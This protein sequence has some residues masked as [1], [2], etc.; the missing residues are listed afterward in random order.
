M[1]RT[2][3]CESLSL[4]SDLRNPLIS[5][6]SHDRFFTWAALEQYLGAVACSLPSLRP[7][8]AVALK[9]SRNT[10][11][12]PRH[13]NFQSHPHTRSQYH[14]SGHRIPI[15]HESCI[16]RTALKNNFISTSTS[17]PDDYMSSSLEK[18]RF[19][20]STNVSYVVNAERSLSGS[21]PLENIA[22]TSLPNKGASTTADLGGIMRTTKVSTHSESLTA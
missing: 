2:L 22:S 21:F 9:N 19:G 20:F 8:V 3:N 12:S 18:S 14:G 16:S 7:L 13:G 10:F 4:N 15:D 11:G 1:I 17:A 5:R 6:N